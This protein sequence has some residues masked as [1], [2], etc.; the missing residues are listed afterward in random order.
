MFLCLTVA[1][2]CLKRLVCMCY[3][4]HCLLYLLFAF[5]LKI[6]V[7][8]IALRFACLLLAVLLHD[9]TNHNLKHERNNSQ[10]SLQHSP[11]QTISCSPFWA[12]P[13]VP[14]LFVFF[15]PSLELFLRL[16]F[17]CNYLSLWRCNR[18][19]MLLRNCRDKFGC[20]TP[21]NM[22]AYTHRRTLAC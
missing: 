12:P 13:S 5:A 18:F 16:P 22:H 17:F 3:V 20:H 19:H 11:S 1:C 15:T 8:L 14:M 7:G 2:P 4:V 21:T 6:S 10:T 9:V